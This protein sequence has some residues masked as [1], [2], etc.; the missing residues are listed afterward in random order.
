MPFLTHGKTNW[1]YILI[2]LILAVIVGGGILVWVEKQEVPSTE[3]PKIE[4]PEK[5]VGDIEKYLYK[6]AILHGVEMPP[7]TEYQA[8]STEEAIL[9][10]VQHLEKEGVKDIKIQHLLW[11]IA[12]RGE[13]FIAGDCSFIQEGKQYNKF[14]AV[15]EDGSEG[16]VGKPS[17]I[18]KDTDIWYSDLVSAD[19]L[20]ELVGRYEVI[21][22]I[23]NVTPVFKNSEIEDETANWKTYLNPEVNFIFRYPN[24]WEIKKDYEYKSAT[25]QVDPKCKG[26]RLVELGGIG[27]SKILISINRPQC[28][29]IKHDTLPGNNWICVFD[30]NLET[31][32]IYEKIKD[33]FQLVSNNQEILFLSPKEGE[34][35]KIGET[36]TI[37]IS[38]PIKHF[39]PFKSLTLHKPNGELVGIVYCKIQKGETTFEWDTKTLYNYCGAGLRDKFE[40]VKPGTYMIAITEAV[41]GLPIIASSESFLV[42][43]E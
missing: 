6:D 43:G 23:Y 5:V 42:V 17:L 31:L 3:L 36:H 1:K 22:D 19:S 39:Y 11:S 9:F 27:D 20:R 15:V 4:K 14:L 38:P 30:D 7:G 28:S 26:V 34:K 40:Q 2:V 13:F 24:N 18:F 33:S 32:N 10:T 12:P 25:C 29:G 16:E 21:A 8:I 41:E 35:W 37:K